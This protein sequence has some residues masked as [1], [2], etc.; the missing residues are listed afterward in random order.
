MSMIK[1]IAQVAPI[2]AAA[3]CLAPSPSAL[4]GSGWGYGD[5]CVPYARWCCP[6][7]PHHTDLPRPY[8]ELTLYRYS[9]ILYGGRIH[10]SVHFR[11]YVAYPRRS[12]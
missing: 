5:C 3:L 7:R 8:P 2:L 12:W 9:Y 11:P 10:R 6:W 4:A 1:R